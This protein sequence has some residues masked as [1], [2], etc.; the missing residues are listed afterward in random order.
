M[1]KQNLE[2]KRD[3]SDEVGMEDVYTEVDDLMSKLGVKLHKIKEA[4]R[5]YA[6][7]M[8]DVPKEA[9]YLKLMYPYSSKY[10]SWFCSRR[11]LISVQT[12]LCLWT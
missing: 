2:H 10:T 12:R 1:L 7:E 11:M 3:T 8:T 4:R 9:D 6:F 5:R